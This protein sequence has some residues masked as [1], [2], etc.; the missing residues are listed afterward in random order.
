M[1]Y[2]APP[3]PVLKCWLQEMAKKPHENKNFRSI[4]VI[5][6]LKNFLC[7]FLCCIVYDLKQIVL[8]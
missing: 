5:L 2:M 3:G 1:G 8:L 6:A 7:Y 4:H